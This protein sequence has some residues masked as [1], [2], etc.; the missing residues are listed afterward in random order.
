MQ[1]SGF[2]GVLV[3]QTVTVYAVGPTANCWRFGYSGFG[4]QKVGDSVRAVGLLLKDSTSGNTVLLAHY[5]DGPSFPDP[6]FPL[7]TAW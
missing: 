2:A 7:P 3:P 6:T 1:I 5:V 4:N